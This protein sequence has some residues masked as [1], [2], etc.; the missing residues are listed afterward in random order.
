MGKKLFALNMKSEVNR[1][2]ARVIKPTEKT[3]YIPDFPQCKKIHFSAA[4]S[5]CFQP[6]AS[7]SRCSK[8]SQKLLW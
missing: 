4:I 6:Y 3:R 2:K 5:L 8:T 7:L 1:V